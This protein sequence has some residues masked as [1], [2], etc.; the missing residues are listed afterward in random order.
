LASLRDKTIPANASKTNPSNQFESGMK[1]A[2]SGASIHS[3][4]W[5]AFVTRTL[6]AQ[7]AFFRRDPDWRRVPSLA[8]LLVL[9]DVPTASV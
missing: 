8:A 2:A 5:I 1:L 3:S 6:L 4:M 7:R 9:F